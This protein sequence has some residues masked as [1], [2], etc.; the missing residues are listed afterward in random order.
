MNSI[1][2][3]IPGSAINPIIVKERGLKPNHTPL[4]F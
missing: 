4:S 1:Q 3:F 2:A